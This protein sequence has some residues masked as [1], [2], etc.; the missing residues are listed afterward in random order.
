MNTPTRRVFVDTN[1]LI[2]A[3]EKSDG[4]KQSK[5]RALVT[6]LWREQAGVLSPQ[7]LAEFYHVATRKMTPPL[8]RTVAR[9]IVAVYRQWCSANTSTTADLLVSASLLE[10][11]HTLSWWDSMIVEA[12]LLSGATTLLSED[13]QHG[14]TFGALTVRNPFKEGI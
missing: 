2:Y 1:I 11:R 7:V 14:R 6:E 5:A 12:A 9:K 4:S 13:M 3:Y 10:E 8:P